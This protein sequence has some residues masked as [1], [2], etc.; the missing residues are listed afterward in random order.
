MRIKTPETNPFLCSQL[1]FD[2]PDNSQKDNDNL[3]DK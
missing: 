3:K 1:G 2:K